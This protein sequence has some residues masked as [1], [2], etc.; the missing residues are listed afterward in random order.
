[1][2]RTPFLL[3]V[4]KCKLHVI[5]NE[6]RVKRPHRQR[7]TTCQRRGCFAM[8]AMTGFYFFD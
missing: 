8:P 4:G 7:I 3:V 1:M 6:E 2:S 5:A